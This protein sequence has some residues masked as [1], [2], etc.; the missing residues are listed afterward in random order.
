MGTTSAGF[1]YPDGGYTSG[2]RQ[3][4]EDLAD[5]A[6]DVIL[7]AGTPRYADAAARTSA[8]PAPVLGMKTVLT[9]TE[10]VY[11]YDGSTWKEWESDWIIWTTAPSNLVVGSG[12]PAS[13]LQRYKWIN[14]R[15]YFN[16]KF[17]LGSSGASMGTQPTL[18]LPLSVILRIPA[19]NIAEGDAGAY[20]LSLTTGYFCKML[21]QTA[22]TVYI[23]HTYTGSA[24]STINS[25]S[26]FTW[27]AGD[28]LAGGFWGDPA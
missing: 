21:I 5:S 6:D 7:E 28:M 10:I 22:T 27:A 3:A 9:S 4:I 17:I 2:W 18:N 16:F 14:G 19:N 25:T 24:T 12:G 23:R 13:S 11:R 1:I 15:I 26:P 8:I 20:D